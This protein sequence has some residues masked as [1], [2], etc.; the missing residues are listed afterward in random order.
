MSKLK[1]RVAFI[2]GASKGLGFGIAEVFAREGCALA[3]T[4]RNKAELADAAGR[5]QDQGAD[6]LFAA[7]DV[8]QESHVMEMFQQIDARWGRIDLVVNNA[9]V[10]DGGPLSELSVEAWDRVMS[11]NLRGPFLC[12]REAM[13]RMKKQGGGRIINIGSISAQRVRPNSGPYSTSKHGLWGLTQVT[14]LEGRADNITCGCI[15]PGNIL[16][17]RRH[18]ERQEDQEPMVS[19]HDIAEVALTM[20]SLPPHCEMLEAIVLPHTQDYIGR[21]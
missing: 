10:F 1:D 3:I 19:P 7:G 8:G 21:G 20:A 16:V 13:K 4:S 5:L 6:V 11:T 15:H 12:T 14:A 9:G 18:T 17:E 2:T